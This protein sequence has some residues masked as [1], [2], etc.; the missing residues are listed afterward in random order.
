MIILGGNFSALIDRGFSLFPLF[1]LFVFVFTGNKG[2]KYLQCYIKRC[3]NV[4][5]AG[6][7]RS[8]IGREWEK[9]K[10]TKR[11]YYI[12]KQT[13]PLSVSKMDRVGAWTKKKTIDT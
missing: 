9:K 11:S 3:V 13:I 2:G 7:N 12:V 4:R 6:A 5:L 10:E 8:P 1:F